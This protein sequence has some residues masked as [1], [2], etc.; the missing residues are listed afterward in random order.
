MNFPRNPGF[1]LWARIVQRFLAQRSCSARELSPELLRLSIARL[2]R[3]L[4][5]RRGEVIAAEEELDSVH[6]I[7]QARL[8]FEAA[9]I[10]LAVRGCGDALLGPLSSRRDLASWRRAALAE[11]HLALLDGADAPL[12]LVVCLV[13]APASWAEPLNLALAGLGLRGS[14]LGRLTHARAWIARGI[15]CPARDVLA[16]L[17][18]SIE[19]CGADYWITC[20]ACLEQGGD[21]RAALACFL[22]AAQDAAAPGEWARAIAIGLAL[23]VGSR[24][25]LERAL[26][27]GGARGDSHPEIQEEACD[28]IRERWSRWT[29]SPRRT[30]HRRETWLAEMHAGPDPLARAIAS[31]VLHIDVASDEHQRDHAGRAR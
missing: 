18:P 15:D 7:E 8:F 14:W 29:P 22:R 21:L 27:L 25:D 2:E 24:D 17:A 4:A 1:R 13:W 12:G 10:A 19:E 30:S 5:V 31:V 28:R 26:A 11:L 16:R 23:A 3:R 20:A 6:R 9:G